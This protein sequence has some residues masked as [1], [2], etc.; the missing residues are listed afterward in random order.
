MARECNKMD[1]KLRF[2]ARYLDGEKITRLRREFG[3][4]WVT[5]HKTI[6]RY[7][8]CGIALAVCEKTAGRATENCS[9]AYV[10]V[11][12]RQ[13]GVITLIHLQVGKFE[14]PSKKL[15]IE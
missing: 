15:S 4:S 11:I 9:R 14:V 7:K 12:G 5:G 8:D 1:K 10:D 6:D 13:V 2:L 3:I